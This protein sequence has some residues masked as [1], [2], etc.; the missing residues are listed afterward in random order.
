MYMKVIISAEVEV[1]LILIYTITNNKELTILTK[2]RAI[3]VTH[4]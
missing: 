2:G 3:E 4:A 1:L